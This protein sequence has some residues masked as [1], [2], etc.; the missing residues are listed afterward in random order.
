MSIEVERRAVITK[1]Q[2]DK[3]FDMLQ[4]LGA[5][6]L[7]ENNTSNIF[8]LSESSQLKITSTP[9][10]GT[11]KVVWKPQKMGSGTNAEELELPIQPTDTEGFDHLFQRITPS[12]ERYVTSQK[13]HDFS[14]DDTTIS[15]K[16]SQDWGYH[17]EI[18]MNVDTQAEAVRALEA[19]EAVAKRLD[20]TLLTEVEEAALVERLIKAR[21]H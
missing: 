8:F 3:L 17:L 1:A 7:G 15:L 18:D 21:K 16:H 20:V 13:R 11:A 4:M 12:F 5:Q 19:I 10:K 2:Y 9:S 6:D 14:L